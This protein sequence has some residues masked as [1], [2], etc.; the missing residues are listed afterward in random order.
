MQI[1]ALVENHSHSP[2]QAKH[3]L[4]LYIETQRHKLLFDLGPD[5]TLFDNARRKGI[6]LTQ[7]DTVILSHGHLDHGG[8]LARFLSLNTTAK[9]YAQK[10]AFEPHYSKLAFLKVPIGLKRRL[11]ARSLRRRLP[12]LRSA[13][14][15]DRSR[16]PAERY[17]SWPAPIP[18]PSFTP[19]TAPVK[20]LTSSSKASCQRY[21]TSPA[22]IPSPSQR[23]PKNAG[24]RVRR[25]VYISSL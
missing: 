13:H 21:P 4:A 9:I 10:S 19:A 23:M 1:T 25:F 5:C 14:Q 7:V 16:L 15:K 24:P 18:R 2:L 3:G 8:A 20:R 12:S 11:H 17:R 6:D 22:A